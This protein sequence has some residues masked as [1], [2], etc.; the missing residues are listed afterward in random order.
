MRKTAHQPLREPEPP[1]MDTNTRQASDEIISNPFVYPESTA[2][3]NDQS[4]GVIHP[5]L[6]RFADSRIEGEYRQAGLKDQCRQGMIIAGVVLALPT[7]QLFVEI[8]AA[9]RDGGAIV[10]IA[11]VRILTAVLSLGL[12]VFLRGKPSWCA[13]ERWL[14]AYGIYVFGVT[15][16][17]VGVHPD[18]A[19]MSITTIVATTALIYFC[20]PLQFVSVA[21]LALITSVGGA[22]AYVILR[23]IPLGEDVFRLSLWIGSMNLLGLFWTNRFNRTSRRLFWEQTQVTQQKEKAEAALR[24]EREALEQSRQLAELVSHEV[25]TPLSVVKSKAQLAQLMK[26][27]G[28]GEDPEAMAAIER[29]VCYMENLFDD[30]LASGQLQRDSLAV[31]ASPVPL[32]KV[33]EEVAGSITHSAVHAITFADIS[34]EIHVNATPGLLRLAVSNIIDNAV[35]YSPEGGRVEIEVFRRGAGAVIR[36]SDQGP[37]IP[38]DELGHVFDR[39]FR[40]AQNKTI[41]GIGLGLFLVRRIMEGHGGTVNIESKVGE[42]TQVFL[43]LP[44]LA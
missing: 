13:A 26:K 38:E 29:A 40:G 43:E 8:P 31:K 34:P 7:L 6:A 32:S 18:S 4:G 10:Y 15:V 2:N 36:V 22:V 25:R 28:K 27:T 30:W 3:N 14:T 9:L 17:I 37:G 5:G 24:G 35:K 39:Y 44:A 19:N 33:L 16:F 1:P 11:M 21:G 12:I 20:A 23:D 42:G 41:R